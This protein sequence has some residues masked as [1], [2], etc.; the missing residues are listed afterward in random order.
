MMPVMLT[1]VPYAARTD[2]LHPLRQMRAALS[3]EIDADGYRNSL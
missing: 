2:G 1:S 3:F